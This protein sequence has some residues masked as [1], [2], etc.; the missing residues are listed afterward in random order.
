MHYGTSQHSVII[1][2]IAAAI[3]TTKVRD[4]ETDTEPLHPSLP[5]VKMQARYI[6][7][8]LAKDTYWHELNMSLELQNRVVPTTPGNIKHEIIASSQAEPQIHIYI[9]IYSNIVMCISMSRTVRINAGANGNTYTNSCILRTSNCS[10][11]MH[12]FWNSS[13]A[14]SSKFLLGNQ[15]DT[16]HDNLQ[17]FRAFTR[18][19]VVDVYV[20]KMN[21]E[22]E[23]YRWFEEPQ[24]APV[25][26][27]RW[28]VDVELS[29]N[30]GTVW[31][32]T[33]YLVPI[34]QFYTPT[35][36]GIR[37]VLGVCAGVRRM[38]AHLSIFK[39]ANTHRSNGVCSM[40]TFV[41]LKGRAHAVVHGT[42]TYTLSIK[43]HGCAA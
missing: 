2:V 14:Q 4:A 43:K 3:R 6:R 34:W 37:A 27:R 33:I 29:S 28:V 24:W 42:C 5:H 41:F 39:V 26:R 1:A 21:E 18:M 40:L 31:R 38:L 12:S 13:T 30:K 36:H 15:W 20:H 17:V 10:T 35:P 11:S 7:S 9:N 32:R 8:W 16:D 19:H 22:D 23:S 25:D